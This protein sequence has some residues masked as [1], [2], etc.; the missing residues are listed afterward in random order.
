MGLINIGE[1][2]Y[3]NA[4]LQILLHCKIFVESCFKYKNPFKNNIT[5]SFIDIGFE[6]IN[7]ENNVENEA[8]IIKSFSPKNFYN[9][10]IKKHPIFQNGQQ[11]SIEFL[12]VLLNDISLENNRNKLSDYKEL[13]LNGNNKSKHCQE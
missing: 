4:A 6:M 1:S 7:K 13:N 3:M 10:F 2:C 11:D 9:E 5:N 8:Y 12:R